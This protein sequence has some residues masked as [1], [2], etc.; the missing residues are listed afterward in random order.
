MITIFILLIYLKKINKK[1][2][3]RR[4]FIEIYSPVFSKF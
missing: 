3:Q 2:A 1:A 4:F